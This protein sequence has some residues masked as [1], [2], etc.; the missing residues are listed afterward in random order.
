MKPGRIPAAPIVAVRCLPVFLLAALCALPAV[1]AGDASVAGRVAD[2]D[3]RPVAGAR[4]VVLPVERVEF[5]RDPAAWRDRSARTEQDGTFRVPVPPGKRFHLEVRAH[6][7]APRVVDFPAAPA[8]KTVDAGTVRLSRGAA[9]SLVLADE[10]GHP[11]SGIPFR[12]TVDTGSRWE[13][14]TLGEADGKWRGERLVV[15]GISP[16]TRRLTLDA[17][18]YATVDL[19]E[20]DLEEGRTVDLGRVVLRR[21]PAIEGVVLSPAGKPVAGAE[22]W[23]RPAGPAG[24]AASPRKTTRTGRDGRFLLGGLAED[25]TYTVSVAPGK[26]PSWEGT[27]RPG[28]RLEIRLPEPG[29]VSGRAVLGGSGKPATPVVVRYHRLDGEENTPSLPGFATSRWLDERQTFRESD[30][31]F[32]LENLAPGTY[33]LAIEHPG[34]LP[35]TLDRVEVPEGGK[36][37]LGTVTLD[38]GVELSGTVVDAVT[39]EPV[40]GAVVEQAAE[41]PFLAIR[42]RMDALS[43]EPEEGIRT[44]GKGRFTLGGLRPG[45]VALE[46][47]AD[48]YSSARV[49]TTIEEGRTPDPLRVELSAGGA[50]EGTVRRPD[51]T[52]ATGVQVMVMRGMAPD[53]DHSAETDAA[54]HYRIE[55]LPPGPVSLVAMLADPAAKGGFDPSGLQV[56][57]VTVEAGKTL[58][59]DFPEGSGGIVLSGRVLAGGEPVAAR[60]TFVQ[61]GGRIVAAKSDE[62]G[63]YRVVLPAPGTWSVAILRLAG[64]SR[65]GDGG[66]TVLVATATARL[67]VPPGVPALSRDI[68]L[69]VASVRG[70]VRDPDGNPLAGAQ[71][72]LRRSGDGE[73][74]GEQG[75]PAGT[76]A[77]DGTFHLD[78]VPAGTWTLVGLARGHAW[79]ETDPFEVGEKGEVEVDLVL[80]SAEPVAARVLDPAGRPLDGARVV[81]LDAPVSLPG[82]GEPAATGGDGTVRL[83]GL[84]EGAWQVAAVSPRFG[85]ALAEIQAPAPGGE[86]QEIPS[87]ET[88]PVP[89][90]VRDG[91]GGSPVPGARLVSARPR[92]GPETRPALV[93]AALLHGRSGGLGSDS[94]GEI[95]LPPLPPGRWEGSV[96]CPGDDGDPVPV[97]FRVAGSEPL[98]VEVTC[99]A[100][101]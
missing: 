30:G 98:T 31:S 55:H 75:S 67:E 32:H 27:A 47:R 88:V 16:G 93:L 11:L 86:I 87:E 4:V 23:A 72:L 13:T 10:E 100:G 40:P 68:P 3:G 26:G 45:R 80:P 41:D 84:P 81:V 61:E 18:G 22:V 59:V 20:V 73:A 46:V 64:G 44:D 97:R 49:E 21:G 52:P 94:G 58:R 60:L 77:R 36:V 92:G 37:D 39:G 50:V 5:L 69:P 6:G 54:G 85:L 38:P 28:D 25:T 19:G 24:G 15:S 43:G 35:Y 29:A 90:V 51:G 82:L 95:P 42:R 74:D 71:V 89:L 33:R 78:W 48:G 70:T 1:A 53:L 14:R 65:E 91:D 76:T 79:Q 63:R 96:R 99:P 101:R 12:L 62:E 83:D 2:P 8:G 56:R 9:V 57:T 17:G 7:F 66:T 34:A